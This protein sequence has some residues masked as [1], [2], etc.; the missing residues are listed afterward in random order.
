M[1]VAVCVRVHCCHCVYARDF[2]QVVKLSNDDV[3]TAVGSQVVSDGGLVIPRSLYL[4]NPSTFSYS[5]N[6]NPS[7]LLTVRTPFR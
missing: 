1:R 5:D 7:Q 2:A 4:S 3:Y 6:P